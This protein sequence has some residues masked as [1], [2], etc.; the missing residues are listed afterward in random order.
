MIDQELRGYARASS[1][2]PGI[3]V[4]NRT[5]RAGRIFTVKSEEL[6]DPEE[7]GYTVLTPG[8]VSCTP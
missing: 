7:L 5:Y 8:L 6:L 4:A 1:A 2:R 3:T